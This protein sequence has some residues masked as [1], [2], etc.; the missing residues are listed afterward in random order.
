VRLLL[1]VTET[2][3]VPGKGIIVLL[4]ELK[5]IGEE[6]FRVGDLLRLRKPDGAEDLV[7]IDGLEFLKPIRGNCQLVVTLAGKSREDVPVGTEVWSVD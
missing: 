3:T 5:P 1:T 6:R 4:P 7:P 2:F